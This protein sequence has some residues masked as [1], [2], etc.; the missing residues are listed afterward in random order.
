MEGVKEP[1]KTVTYAKTASPKKTGAIQN[2][3]QKTIL[4]EKSGSRKQ[5]P[6]KMVKM[7][8]K[9]AV[10]RTPD[11]AIFKI[12]PVFLFANAC[13]DK[14]TDL[15]ICQASVRMTGENNVIAAQRFGPIWHLYP[16]TIEDRALL[17]GGTLT[18]D[19]RSAT[20]FSKNPAHL[21]NEYNQPIPSA[22]LSITGL[23][24][25]LPSESITEALVQ[26]GFKPRSPILYDQ[27]Q[28]TDAIPST[29]YSGIR[30]VYIDIPSKTPLPFLTLASYVCQV[31]YIDY[32]GRGYVKEVQNNDQPRT[33]TRELPKAQTHQTYAQA[34]KD[35]QPRAEAL[36]SN[37]DTSG[38]EVSQGNGDLEE[39]ELPNTIISQTTSLSASD[40]NVIDTRSD[41]N[42]KDMNDKI[43]PSVS[44]N[45]APDIE[46]EDGEL[47]DTT[48]NVSNNVAP[49]IELEDGELP[50]SSPS[51]SNNVAPTI[52][53]ED[54]E[55]PNTPPP[56]TAPLLE[57][58]VIDVEL[59]DTSSTLNAEDLEE[60]FIP[61]VSNSVALMTN[62]PNSS[63]A[64]GN[65]FTPSG[66]S[67]GEAVNAS[68]TSVLE[69]NDPASDPSDHSP[70]PVGCTKGDTAHIDVTSDTSE[71]TTGVS[72]TTGV[73]V[74]SALPSPPSGTVIGESANSEAP[75]ANI[76]SN[77]PVP[78]SPSIHTPALWVPSSGDS[79]HSD[80]KP[81]SSEQ[82]PGV[83]ITSSLNALVMGELSNIEASSANSEFILTSANAPGA[84]TRPPSGSDMEETANIESSFANIKSNSPVAT[85]PSNHAPALGVPLPSGETA[86]NDVTSNPA[87]NHTPGLSEPSS[88]G[89][90]SPSDVSSS[91]SNLASNHTPALS[92]PSSGDK[93]APSEVSSATS[94]FVSNHTPALSVPSSSGK[95]ALSEVSSPTSNLAPDMPDEADVSKA[96]DLLP[97]SVL[98]ALFA[99]PLVERDSPCSSR[100]NI[101]V[102]SPNKKAQLSSI[103]RANSLNSS[104]L[105]RSRGLLP[106]REHSRSRSTSR[107]R[108][109][110]SMTDVTPEGPAQRSRLSDGN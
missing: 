69:A 2:N 74:H 11:P 6:K 50:D 24:L 12:P 61:S 27:I 70:A 17:A 29:W 108:S 79:A 95:S 9:I 107:K 101:K 94:N 3:K 47:P 14:V 65:S 97:A 56:Q 89:K 63:D 64:S 41:L 5:N 22:K 93:S 102:N 98:E 67:A 33:A 18:I 80:S 42:I 71:Q 106:D 40:K 45:D 78:S 43:T 105:T 68:S 87:S 36:S 25:M 38:K 62:P 31:D 30:T 82:T 51:V 7:K 96:E 39:G 109:K 99:T 52:E 104:L 37:V 19:G 13:P 60:I 72:I 32:L 54:G 46:L 57:E 20:L 55:L 103:P 21:I 90:S 35:P 81:D 58:N 49:S 4:P 1:W 73:S 76:E 92:V 91:T 83:S 10:N 44:N 53:L 59:L 48:P 86:L 8:T 110:D 15:Q 28:I 84:Q 23:P 75:T 26:E 88:G 16:K 34:I 85:T 66:N 77:S 100:G